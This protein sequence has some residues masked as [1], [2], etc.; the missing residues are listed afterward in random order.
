MIHEVEKG[1]AEL[2]K[3]VE[4]E[5]VNKNIKDLAIHLAELVE[6]F[7]A[8]IR[9][10]GRT[11]EKA[12]DLINNAVFNTKLRL[13]FH[14]IALEIDP[15]FE[16]FEVKCSSRLTISTLMNLIDNSIWWLDNKWGEAPGKKKIYIG[17][18]R[19]LGGAPAIIVADN[20]PGFMDLP[21][22]LVEPFFSRKP[23]GMGLGLHLADQ[24]MKAQGG[25][26]EFPVRDLLALPEVYDGAIVALVFK[27]NEA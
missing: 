1:V 18:S 14:G 21:E 6:G 3:A 24:V 2:A 4:I 16:D 27:E 13:K 26:L 25:R 17:T 12:G 15:D 23:D 5:P 20:G 19:Q 9:R 7:A 11:R 8:L 10:S 22:E